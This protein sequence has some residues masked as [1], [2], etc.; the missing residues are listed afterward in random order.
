MQ[1]FFAPADRDPSEL[2]LEDSRRMQGLGAMRLI[3]DSLPEVAMI[4]NPKRQIVFAN[5]A[6]LAAYGLSLNEITG[7]RA[8][9]LAACIHSKELPGGCGTAEACRF[10]ELIKAFMEAQTSSTRVTREGRMTTLRDGKLESLDLLVTANRISDGIRDYT[11]ITLNDI[12]DTKRRKV[13]ERIF[14][15]DVLN[16]IYGLQSSAA[17][18]KEEMGTAGKEYL[19]Y[20]VR[21]VEGLAEEVERQRDFIS[22]ERGELQVSP[23][24]VSAVEILGDS[25]GSFRNGDAMGVRIET[26]SLP[27]D[28]APLETDPVLL[29]RVLVNIV[30][31]A[32]EASEPGDR[33][34]AEVGT[35]GDRVVMRVNN[36]AV[37][38]ESAQ[39]QVFQRSFSTKGSG[40]G[41]GTYSMR[42]LVRDYLK[43]DIELDSRP[44]AGTTFSVSLPAVF[45]Q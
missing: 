37:M 24:L 8:G 7:M 30:K 42:M 17:L 5:E 10:C 4:L 12:S 14:F 3:L 20:I 45:P 18:L 19:D 41:I 21:S 28:G 44:E 43:G 32:V 40:R 6:T 34:L 39:S 29:R 1:T 9:E 26:G 2:V 16:S 27:R 38:T 35:E 23:T 25:L 36:P 11:V 13:L 15:H 22:M 31:N 33:V